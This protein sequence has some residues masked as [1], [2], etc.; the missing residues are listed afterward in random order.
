MRHIQ[1]ASLAKL[2]FCQ[3][4]CKFAV[5]NTL[6]DKVACA[7]VAL[8]IALTQ[9]GIDPP[10]AGRKASAVGHCF[11]LANSAICW[12]QGSSTAKRPA[13][14]RQTQAKSPD[15]AGT[16]DPSGPMDIDGPDGKA[17]LMRVPDRKA[18]PG[19]KGILG[20]DQQARRGSP[21]EDFHPHDQWT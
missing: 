9:N 15:I 12:M 3:G 18:Q 1:T 10:P 17:D 13:Q 2:G 14:S 7:G 8:P 4:I 21:G 5:S 20:K 19:A 6:R 16:S 11:A